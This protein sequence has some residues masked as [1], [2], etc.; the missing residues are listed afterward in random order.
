MS[1]GTC[2]RPLVAFY[3]TYT[4]KSSLLDE[5]KVLTLLD[6]FSR[7]LCN[8]PGDKFLVPAAYRTRNYIFIF[9]DCDFV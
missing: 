2:S 4:K 1:E 3:K 7:F 6:I 8:S 5:F 9:A